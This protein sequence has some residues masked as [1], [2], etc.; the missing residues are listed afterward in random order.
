MARVISPSGD[1]GALQELL[2]EYNE[3][4]ERQPDVVLRVE[5]RFTRTTAIFVLDSSGFSR[6]TRLHGVVHFL[7]MLEKLVRLAGPIIVR[8]NGRIL[9]TEADNVF[10]VFGDPQAALAAAVE[11]QR[12]LRAANEALPRAQEIYASIGIGYGPVL[13]I[14]EDDLFGDEMNLACKLGEDL[15]RNGEILLTERAHSAVGADFEMLE[16]TI[17]GIELRAFRVPVEAS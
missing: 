3:F 15:G 11:I 16:F 6:I 7:A 12:S 8:H 4:P 13:A 17:S 9:K 5:E 1:R 14:G 10:A 2:R